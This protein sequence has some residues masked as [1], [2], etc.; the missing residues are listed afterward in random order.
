M[1]EILK[2]IS[3]VAESLKNNLYSYFCVT[4]LFCILSAPLG[5]FI[6]DKSGSIGKH[7]FYNWEKL[8]LSLILGFSCL[9]IIFY[10]SVLLQLNI[11][12]LIFT[13]YPFIALWLLYKKN[14]AS[15]EIIDNK[16]SFSVKLT[17][18]AL[19]ILFI[20]YSI[21]PVTLNYGFTRDYDIAALG[22][23]QTGN[24][25]LPFYNIEN[26]Y[27]PLVS[28]VTA[29]LSK[30]INNLFFLNLNQLMISVFSL[31]T[32]LLFALAYFIGLIFFNNRKAGLC[33]LGMMILI[34]S[35][36]NAVIGGST[37]PALLSNFYFLVFIICLGE[38]FIYGNKKI[39]LLS[40][41]SFAGIFLS[42]LDIF[43]SFIGFLLAALITVMFYKEKITK[44]IIFLLKTFLISL[45]LIIPYLSYGLK[46]KNK[47][48]ALWTENRWMAKMIGESHPKPLNEIIF[49]TG[50]VP[51]LIAFSAVIIF[52]YLFFFGK[53]IKNKATYLFFI[54]WTI[55]IFTQN[56]WTMAH[57]SKPFIHIYPL[58]IIMWMGLTVFLLLI[59]GY[60]SFMFENY[61][62]K[63]GKFSVLFLSS[64]VIF[65]FINIADYEALNLQRVYR[66]GAGYLWSG[67][68]DK[69]SILSTGDNKLLD[70][71]KNESS[72]DK[73]LT[74]D[75][76]AGYFLAVS[77][78]K[79]SM[80]IFYEGESYHDP[81]FLPLMDNIYAQT[82]KF[83]NTPNSNESKKF[84]NDHRLKYIYLPSCQDA[85]KYSDDS[86]SNLHY[87]TALLNGDFEVL[88]RS[89]GAKI[90]R[91]RPR[92]NS[93]TRLFHLEAE[94]FSSLLKTKKYYYPKSIS[95]NTVILKSDFNLLIP[96]NLDNYKIDLKKEAI[97]HIKYLAF[98][99]K[100][101]IKVSIGNFST[102]LKESKGR[103]GFTESMIKVPSDYFL[104]TSKKE[105]I[106]EI[107]ILPVNILI[108]KLLEL[109]PIEI[110]WVE[111]EI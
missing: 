33:F 70:W 47:F 1:A 3:V 104:N 8:L 6:L 64:F 50:I 72:L 73:F 58:N 23:K 10:F 71:A 81:K 21:Q 2:I 22:L 16:D 53:S 56:S 54:L 37:Y 103:I 65:G 83:F 20:Y 11:N 80:L 99:W 86:Q 14:K 106:L 61:L 62:T 42:H 27:P 88:K 111:I 44:V 68:S 39:V 93:K 25:V 87:D 52:T 24:F 38:Y 35:S 82:T 102:V 34:P 67:F 45:P 5:Y 29:S 66:P 7:K 79:K 9:A 59:G 69:N 57:L 4:G 28:S 84:L 31:I 90:I 30:I 15:P 55:F 110:D 74:P 17:L 36:R 105:T 94:E 63:K 100:V 46:N 12:I 18:T 98:P 95:L 32:F 76:Y 43:I 75:N 78:E 96:L 60:A 40:G 109:L 85:G 101:P 97:I 91:Y 13:L 48:S 107:S 26:Y 41:L 19:V 92:N 77:T 49:F 89:A 51:W 108:G